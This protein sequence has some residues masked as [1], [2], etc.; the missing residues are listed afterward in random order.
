MTIMYW[1]ICFLPLSH[2][3]TIQLSVYPCKKGVLVIVHGYVYAPTYVWL[4]GVYLTYISHHGVGLVQLGV[5]ESC[6]CCVTE[7]SLT[8]QPGLPTY[9]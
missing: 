8:S 9:I 1:S 5:T 4:A 7:C 2:G 3:P 6:C